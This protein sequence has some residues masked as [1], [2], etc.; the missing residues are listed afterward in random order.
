MDRFFG[1]LELYIKQQKI[2][3]S[4]LNFPSCTDMKYSKDFDKSKNESCHFIG[5][6]GK[7]YCFILRLSSV[8]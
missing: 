2:D 4:H 5:L 6:F 7:I 1:A 8:I 3:F